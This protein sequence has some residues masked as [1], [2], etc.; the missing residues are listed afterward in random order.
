MSR[1]N[2]IA[3]TLQGEPR[4]GTLEAKD[5][6]ELARI[7][8]REG[9]ILIKAASEE[10]KHKK[11]FLITVPFLGRVSLTEKIMFTRNLRV[12]IAAG[13]ALP[14]TLKILAD[15]AKNKKFRKTLLE[16]R[17]EIVKGRAF[18][19]SLDK[20]PS[21]FSE[22]FVSMVKVGEE[23]GTLEEVLR[24]LTQQM[25]KEHEIKSSIKGAMIY[26]AVIIFA[27]VCIGVLMLIIVIPKLAAVFSELGVELP[28]TT[29]I[30]IATGT[31]L[32]KFWFLL[33]VGILIFLFL[34]RVILKTKTGKLVFD[35]F[36]LK[37]PVISSIIKK[38]NSAHTV[39]T[40]SSLIAAG[41][42]IVRSLEIVSGTLGNVHYRKAMSEAAERVKKGAKLAEI[43]KRY[44]N[45]YPTLVIQMIEVGEETG[46][47]SDVLE[48][49][50]EFFEEEVANATKNL[51]AVI[52][53]VLMLIV[54]AVVGFFAISMIQPIYS[55]MG[56][57]YNQESRIMNYEFRKC[58][59]VKRGFTL[60]EILII[61]GIIAVLVGIG[62]P[63]FRSF[64]PVLQLN[65]AVRDL[66]TDLRYAQQLAV[67]EQ[68]EHCVRFFPEDK[69][70]KIIQC[71]NPGAEEI[72][73]TI[74]FQEIN[75]ITV[76]DFSDNEAR[77]NPYGSVK[78]DGAVTLEV[79]GKTKTIEVRP[80]GF[81]KIKKD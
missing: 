25:E 73:K 32:S 57:L 9:S 45:I 71:Q 43:L 6:H 29:K 19:E 42:P 48:K 17:E 58:C 10:E 30:V 63:V 50:A 22:L 16:I 41:V 56:T 36:V 24:V 1:Y 13:V 28:L 55:M 77:Y 2:Y 11:K 75:S 46:K 18:S 38:T 4:S 59:S 72:L 69:E 61:I 15:Q 34:L 78:K 8:R 53:P 37:I 79:N 52:E 68:L 76:A 33:P 21:I 60:I 3:K 5:E 62:I 74:S 7:L 26:P 44:E 47:T 70:Y 65:G 20:Y 31:F 49:L 54:G 35:T 64:Q 66:V 81:V 23:T 27:M 67:T 12:M 39:R 40:L 51:S 80:S 14:R